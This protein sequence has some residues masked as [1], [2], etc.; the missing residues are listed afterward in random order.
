[1]ESSYLR[2]EAGAVLLEGGEAVTR[3][4]ID[5]QQRVRF[6]WRVAAVGLV[7]SGEWL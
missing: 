4:G 2:P 5:G 3:L 7:V 6:L 1:M